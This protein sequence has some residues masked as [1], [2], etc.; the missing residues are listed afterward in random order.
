MRLPQP[1][2]SGRLSVGW[3]ERDRRAYHPVSKGLATDRIEHF[4]HG[5]RSEDRR[6]ARPEDDP[7]H[8]SVECPGIRLLKRQGLHGE[9]QFWFD[10]SLSHDVGILIAKDLLRVPLR[11]V[12][13]SP[14]ALLTKSSVLGEQRVDFQYLKQEI[15]HRL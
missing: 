6:K 8:D 3:T 4:L 15:G 13:H 1:M 9:A 14:F 7:V 5:I 12:D 2:R 11:E 10:A